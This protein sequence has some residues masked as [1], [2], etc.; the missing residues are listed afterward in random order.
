MMNY[1][2]LFCLSLLL[3]LSYHMGF[4]QLT[5]NT[6]GPYTDYISGLVGP[7]VEFISL[8]SVYCDTIGTSPGNLPAMGQYNGT[9]T[10]AGL[11]NGVVIT[12]G[13]VTFSLPNAGG[14]GVDLSAP[15]DPNL[16]AL[17]A[18]DITNDACGFQIRIRPSCD[19]IR[20][21]YMFASYE[22]PTFVATYN[23]VMGLFVTGPGY[24]PLTN[25]AVVPSTTLPVSIFNVNA[26]TNNAF[27]QA[28]GGGTGYSGRTI[29]LEAV[30][31]VIACEEYT[32]DIS[33]ADEQDNSFDSG[34]FIESFSCGSP[35]PRVIA[36]NFNN[37]NNPEAREDCVDGYFTFFNTFDTTQPLTF[38]LTFLGTATNGVDYNM[39]STITIPAGEDSIDV[40]ANVIS[41]GILEGSETIILALDIFSCD[42]PLLTIFDPFEAEGIAG[43]DTTLCANATHVIGTPSVAGYTYNWSSTFGFIG[44][45]DAAEP[46]VGISSSSSPIGVNYVL[47]VSD[48]N[49]CSVDDSVFVNYS[50]GPPI[51]FFTDNSICEDEFATVQYSLAPNPALNYNWDFGPSVDQVIGTGP[52]PLQVS[53]STPGPKSISLVVDDNFCNSETVTQTINVNPTP[54]SA[55]QMP[56]QACEGEPVQLVYLGSGS[57]ATGSFNWDLDGG[58]G[59]PNGTS[60]QVT[61]ATP[62]VKNIRLKVEDNGCES[63][64]TVQTINIVP[65][66]STNFALQDTLCL[67]DMTQITYTGANGPSGVYS[68]SF[69]GGQVASGTGSGPYQVQWQLPGTKQICLQVNDQGCAS[70]VVCREIVVQDAPSVTIDPQP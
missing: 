60:F 41:D 36:R 40:P 14:N 6:A 4:A 32:L 27:F 16:D 34:V 20:I 44:P 10:A 7:G 67:G 19:T 58:V 15:G 68:W 11:T 28:N 2:R 21:R 59:A 5:V 37:P 63:A 56:L 43:N 9:G 50:P 52:G 66:P 51:A 46:S 45:G 69:D 13:S 39:P 65:T 31:P 61:W 24:A 64:E 23:D 48:E 57:S 17:I 33:V 49:G 8:N 53:W 35:T 47:R 55:F 18:P 30:I 29:V 38:N 62:G 26:A 12:S 3:G 25:V 54:T 42:S 1:L 70:P 22:Y